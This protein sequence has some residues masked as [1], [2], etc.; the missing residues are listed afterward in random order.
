ML[1][2]S[3]MEINPKYINANKNKDA[4][5]MLPEI[6]TFLGS[7]AAADSR[8]LIDKDAANELTLLADKAEGIKKKIGYGY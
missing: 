4:I 5:K 7:I 2:Y 1:E 6:I 8:A 3:T